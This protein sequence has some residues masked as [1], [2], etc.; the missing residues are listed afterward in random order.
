[1]DCSKADRQIQ[2][3]LDQRLTLDQVRDLEKHL[4]TC[5]TCQQIFWQMEQIDRALNEIEMV[6]EPSDLTHRIMQRVAV[7]PQYSREQQQ[8][9]LRPSLRE[10]GIVVLLATVSMFGII[11]GQPELRAGLPFANGHDPLSLAF[12]AFTQMLASLNSSTLTM[13]IWIFGTILGVWITLALAGNEMRRMDW[14]KNMM[15]RLPVRL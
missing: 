12:S 10:V 9:S 1:M 6:A 7:T 15:A 5:H 2:L 14:F 13:V 3:Y 11:M 4:G 8:E